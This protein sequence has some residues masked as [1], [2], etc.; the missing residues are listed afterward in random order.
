MSFGFTQ[1]KSKI[2]PNE[3]SPSWMGLNP[4]H[5]EQNPF[6]KANSYSASQEDNHI[7][8]TWRFITVFKTACTEALCNVQ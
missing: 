5:L 8:G 2:N 6:W 7:Y 3:C 4:G 1:N